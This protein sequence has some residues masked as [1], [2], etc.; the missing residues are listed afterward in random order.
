LKLIIVQD[1][2]TAFLRNLPPETKQDIA[3]IKSGKRPALWGFDLDE[4]EVE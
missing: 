4:I 3:E 1:I 2:V